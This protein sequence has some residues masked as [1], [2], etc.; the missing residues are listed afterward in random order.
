[1]LEARAALPVGPVGM[2]G[3]VV[4]PAV[5][6]VGTVAGPVVGMAGIVAGPGTVAGLVAGPASPGATRT[7]ARRR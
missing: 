6:M 2:A 1:M 5:A 3:T 7:L 4:G